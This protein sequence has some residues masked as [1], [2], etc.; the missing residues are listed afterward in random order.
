MERNWVK[1]PWSRFIAMIAFILFLALASNFEW[2]MGPMGLD[3]GVWLVCYISYGV[4]IVWSIVHVVRSN[5]GEN[6]D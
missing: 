4:L 2:P 3:W 1:V 6:D 5:R